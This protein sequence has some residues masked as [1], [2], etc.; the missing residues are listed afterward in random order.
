MNAAKPPSVPFH[1]TRSML[2]VPASRPSMIAKAAGSAADAVCLDLE[3][4][5]A[6]DAKPAAR[7]HVIGALRELDFGPRLRIMRI[8]ALDTPFA[9]RDLIDVIEAAGDRLDLVMVPKVNQATDLV[10]VAMLL[11][12]IEAHQGLARP[13]GI[14]AQIE[15]AAGLLN[16]REIAQATSRLA[17]LIFGPGDYAASLQM[18]LTSIGEPDSHDA[19]YPG[20]RW[21]MVMHTIVAAARANGL[22]CMDG[23]FAGLRDPAGL[24]QAARI[25]RAMG[26]DG[27]QCIHPAQLASVNAIFMP[28]AA[29]LRWAEEVMQVYAAAQAAGHGA[30]AHAGRMIDAANLRL[31]QAI[32]AQQN[33]L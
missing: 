3:D 29:E 21:H 10:F 25:A 24:E 16:I 28:T 4:A 2:F 32:L 9:Y 14:E 8:N 31:A 20:H 7:S 30:L 12:Q 5:V 22:R 6:P 18:P 15:T 1:R 13:I 11:D 19:L 26:F 23:P 17:A 33:L 27:K